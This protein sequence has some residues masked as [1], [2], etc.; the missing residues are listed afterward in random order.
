MNGLYRY[1]RR[2]EIVKNTV[3]IFFILLLAVVS[4]YYIYQKFQGNH[5][6][7]FSSESLDVTYHE[8]SG[9]KIS[10]TKVIPVTDSVG[11]SSTAYLI[12]IKNN[13]TEKVNYRIKIMDDEEKIKDLDEELIIPKEDIRISIKAGKTAN[14]IYTLDELEDEILLEDTIKALENKSLAIRLWIKQDSLLPTT[15]NMAYYGKIQVI[16]DDAALADNEW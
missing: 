13:L 8:N 16:E 11:L 9:D 1:N 5:D 3:Y 7:D 2:K 14:K 10:L 12:S 15:N 4:T 6:I